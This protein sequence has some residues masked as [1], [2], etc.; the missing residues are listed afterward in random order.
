MPLRIQQLLDALDGIAY[1]TDGDTRL[2]AVGRRGWREFA[3][4]N[5]A[6]ELADGNKLLGR[7][8][9]EFIAGD[10]VK[11]AF[12]HVLE[13]AA[14]TGREVLLPCRCDGPEIVRDMR[15]TIS[16]LRRSHGI[17]GFLFQSIQ[18][19][20]HARPPLALYDF[21]ALQGAQ[22]PLLAMCS[23]CQRV[24]FD[25]GDGAPVWLDAET[26]YAHGGSSWVRISHTICPD[27]FSRWVAGWSGTPSTS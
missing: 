6:P 5:G 13:R 18:L 20:E 12:R 21:R 25:R 1:V 27:C 24:W 23:L 22:R 14:A 2:V 26:Y 8:I 11:D 3:E 17:D 9:F 15:L 16:A 19:T 4:E 7:S 10:T